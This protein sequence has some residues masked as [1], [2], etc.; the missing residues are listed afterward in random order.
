M[1]RSQRVA[2][3][4]FVLLIPVAFILVSCKPGNK[5]PVL[6]KNAGSSV[7]QDTLILKNGGKI[8]GK[9]IAENPSRV[10]ISIEGGELGFPRS[11]IAEIRRGESLISSKD[12]IE[13]SAFSQNAGMIYP[14]IYMKDGQIASGGEIFKDG[15]SFYLKKPV[16]GGGFASFGFDLDKIE[17]ILLWPPPS[18]DRLN[19]DFKELKNLNLKY[20]YQKP[21]Y[22]I[23]STVE[24]SDLVLYFKALERFFHDF[25]FRFFELIDPGKDPG[26]LGVIIFGDYQNFL[27][28]TGLSGNTPIVGFYVPKKKVL[29]LYNLKEIDMIRFQLA[30]AE[31]IEKN[32]GKY[33]TA[34]EMATNV[35][36]EQKW[37]AYDYLEKV[38]FQIESRRMQLEFWARE[39]TIETIRHEGGHQLL[40]LFGIDSDQVYRGA[41]FSEG[42]AEYV[43][44]ENMGDISKERLMFLRSQLEKGHT[45]M[46][47][48]YLMSIKSGEGIH[49]LQDPNYTLLGYAQSWALIYFLM[50]NYQ[51]SFLNYIR[52]L[53]NQDTKFN[54]DRDQALFEKHLGKKIP[55]LDKEFETFVRKIMVERIDQETYDFFR[56]IRQPS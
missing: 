21:P 45:L 42:M 54:A 38:Q 34:L 24:S 1:K 47:L 10:T 40:H 43:A 49:R 14:S 3:F 36:G 35:D 12:G 2:F 41:W 17:K 44:P 55:E 23:V 15:Q 22:Y 13:L 9:I 19:K 28:F 37:A 32:I 31:F 16:E 29:V 56:L 48:Q 25:L 52:D 51:T 39:R 46:P 27:K 26:P 50:E 5:N 18:E 6:E 7:V 11:D 53:R 4:Y 8:Q 20:S 33:K 30:M